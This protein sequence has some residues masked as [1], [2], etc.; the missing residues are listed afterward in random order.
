MNQW[1]TDVPGSAGPK[2]S[3]PIELSKFR[4]TSNVH[5]SSGVTVV[6]LEP[7]GNPARWRAVDDR[8]PCHRDPGRGRRP[9]NCEDE[10]Q[11]EHTNSC[12][13][14]RSQSLHAEYSIERNRPQSR[15]CAASNTYGL[16]TAWVSACERTGGNGGGRRSKRYRAHS[17]G[18][19]D[20]SVERDAKNEDYSFPGSPK[21]RRDVRNALVDTGLEPVRV[22]GHDGVRC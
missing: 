1:L 21:R 8:K 12:H 5:P 9:R 13:V 18:W 10:Y 6:V 2:M 19:L 17:D 7:A 22:F 15:P 11:A 20:G 16:L 4:D 3:K 14:E